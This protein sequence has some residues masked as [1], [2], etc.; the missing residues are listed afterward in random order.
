M[1]PRM[2]GII[3]A[4]IPD[5]NTLYA[6]Y[7][8]YVVGGGLFIPSKQPVKLGEE[9]F[10]LA[11]LPEQSQKIPLTGKV[12]WI[13]HKQ[14]GAKLQGFGIQLMGEKGVYYKSEAE[15]LLAGIKSDGRSSYTM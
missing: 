5:K 3:Q 2:G 4:N 1:Q 8:P 10:V 13:A 12:I 15:K 7:M 11:T 9:V 14:N 6:S